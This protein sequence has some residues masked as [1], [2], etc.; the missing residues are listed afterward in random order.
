MQETSEAGEHGLNKAASVTQRLD[1]ALKNY[2][3]VL[4]SVLKF[5][6]KLH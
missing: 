1:L 6:I 3:F 2:F 5:Y 4:F